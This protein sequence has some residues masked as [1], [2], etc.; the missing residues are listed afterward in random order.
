M[1]QA[2][3]AMKITRQG[4]SQAKSVDNLDMVLCVLYECVS[5]NVSVGVSVSVSVGVKVG[6]VGQKSERGGALLYGFA[7]LGSG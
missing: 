5:V 4:I 2:I 1:R 3:N 7:A 6:N